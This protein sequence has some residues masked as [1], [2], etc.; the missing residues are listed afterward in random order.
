MDA[1]ARN[2][3]ISL[4]K[5]KPAYQILQHPWIHLTIIYKPNRFTFLTIL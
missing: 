3:I 5:I 1:A 4:C 2:E